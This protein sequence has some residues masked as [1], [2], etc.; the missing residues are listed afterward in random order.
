MRGHSAEVIAGMILAD[1]HS[2]NFNQPSWF[3]THYLSTAE[4]SLEVESLEQAGPPAA[5]AVE[6]S[7]GRS[8]TIA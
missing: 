1:V 8:C 2:E 7:T 3:P 4:A 6:K 5:V